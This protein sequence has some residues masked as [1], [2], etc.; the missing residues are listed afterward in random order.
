MHFLKRLWDPTV[1]IV[2]NCL[3]H[4]TAGFGALSVSA[5]KAL[6]LYCL[7][8]RGG[9]S[10]VVQLVCSD[11]H[12]GCP[13]LYMVVNK[14][15]MNILVIGQSHFRFFKKW[16][17]DVFNL[18]SNGSINVERETKHWAN[19][20][21]G[22][23]EFFV[24]YLQLFWHLKLYQTKG[25]PKHCLIVCLRSCAKLLSYPDAPHFLF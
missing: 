5:L 2:L 20:D 8:S 3:V 4:W 1:R 23:D 12:L 19:V 18:H 16:R 22:N 9:Q 7:Y 11:G 17:N 15:K 10:M 21:E 25:Y 13:Q 14:A 24:L 6:S